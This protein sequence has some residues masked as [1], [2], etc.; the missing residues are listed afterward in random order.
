M[1]VLRSH[2]CH[3]VPKTLEINLG[4]KN[5]KGVFCYVNEILDHTKRWGIGGQENQ[6]CNLSVGL[7]VPYA[8]VSRKGRGTKD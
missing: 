3:I 5:D 7:S 8:R 4:A 6:Q 1:F 2:F